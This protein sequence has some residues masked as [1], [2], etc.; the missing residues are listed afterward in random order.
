MFGTFRKH[1]Q[2]LWIAIIIVIVISFVVFFTPDFDPFDT[3]GKITAD[4]A[5]VEKARSQVLID[6]ALGQI[7]NWP[8]QRQML[9]Q[10]LFQAGRMEEAVKLI[11][12]PS[13]YPQLNAQRMAGDSRH[14]DLNGDN[15]KDINSLEYRARV[16]LLQ[17][18]LAKKQLGIMISDSAVNAARDFMVKNLNGAQEYNADQYDQLLKQLS[19]SGFIASGRI[20][21]EE[22]ED[23]LRSRLTLLQLNE[24]MTRSAG[25]WP[26]TDMAETLAQQNRKY[27]IEAAFIS[28]TNHTASSTNYADITK[29]EGFTN[30]FKLVDDQYQVPAR[31]TIA[32]VKLAL[33]DF[34]DDIR[35]ELK[36]DD[37][38][39]KLIEQHN[40]TTNRI[41]ETNGTALPINATNL[42]ARAEEEVRKTDLGKRIFNA[43]NTA[44]RANA[45]AFR[46]SLF[47]QR[48]FA[49]ANL[50]ATAK[51]FSLQIQTATFSRKDAP[52][53]LPPALIAAA[54]APSLKTGKLLENAV[55]SPDPNK[56]DSIY[57][58]GLQEITPPLTREYSELNEEEKQAVNKSF[59][60]SEKNRLARDAGYQFRTAAVASLKEG[61]TFSH[62][63]TNAGLRVVTLPPFSLSTATDTN[64]ID[65]L[66]GL[67]PLHTLQTELKTHEQN[68][69]NKDDPDKE[70]L[71][72]YLENAS[73]GVSTNDTI[74]GY[75]LHITQ[76]IEADEPDATALSAAAAS[77]RQENRNQAAGGDWFFSHQRQLDSKIII[78]SLE[79]RLEGLPSEIREVKENILYKE[80]TLARQFANSLKQAGITDGKK[81]SPLEKWSEAQIGTLKKFASINYFATPPK[82]PEAAQIIVP[83]LSAKLRQPWEDLTKVT[84]ELEKLEKLKDGGIEKAIAEEEKIFKNKK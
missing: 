35:K 14:I 47:S 23:Y 61:A 43:A 2:P 62:A 74:A 46:K 68:Q 36:F 15:Y 17:L 54:F 18:T 39:Q 51:Q 57:I 64:H 77:R 33:A 45:L 83:L 27:A 44:A 13:P 78:S 34:E 71:T 55:Y 52:E 56:P 75:V 40:N 41:T 63:A 26:D 58:L 67:V 66:K 42:L 72:A 48:P 81:I 82:Q 69:L 37:E 6:N 73:S 53:D 5:A 8:R 28:L 25:F 60:Q 12:N 65:L 70:N 3:S 32:Y 9:A 59:L 49:T 76:R 50:E 7:I 10:Q 30:H 19:K 21:Q 11:Q 24:I 29:A 31:R 20:G 16:R 1:S 84:E 38:V 79:S 4:A 22:F 80:Q